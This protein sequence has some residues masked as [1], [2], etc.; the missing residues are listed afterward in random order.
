MPP[1]KAATSEVIPESSDAPKKDEKVLAKA[2]SD[3]SK[4]PPVARKPALHPPTMVMVKEAITELDS[5]KGVS[6]QAI[7][8]YITEKY[9]SVDPIRLKY[10]I[11]KA[12]SKGIEGGVLVRPTNST[13]T[14]AQGRFRLAVR[15]KVKAPK[16]KTTE[17]T[18]PNLEKAPQTA[19]AG[20]K[21]K[22]TDA[23]KK[24]PVTKKQKTSEDAKPKKAA[25]V[26][27]ASK[28][29]PAKKPKAK[30]PAEG[31]AEDQSKPKAKTTRAA[32]GEGASEGAAKTK[33]V[34]AK[35]SQKPAAGGNGE[36]ALPKTTGK[37]GKKAVVVAA[38]AE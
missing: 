4:A 3:S 20:P 35:A 32:K 29:P 1:K 17:N 6:L 10:M 31:V 9:P 11:R 22:E 23:E 30:K 34:K 26:A 7:R 38:A 24:K 21:A 33:K 16:L 2:K 25:K 18:D 36:T 14:G 8:G 12:L 27:S 37:R 5:R 19:K 28:V 15:A 13:A